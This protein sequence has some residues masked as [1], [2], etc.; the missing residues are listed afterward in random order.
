M[1]TNPMINTNTST[2]NHSQ[3]SMAKMALIVESQYCS[4]VLMVVTA[5]DFGGFPT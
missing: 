1:Q 2:L 3:V 5:K 4:I